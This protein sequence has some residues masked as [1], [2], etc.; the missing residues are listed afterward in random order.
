VVCDIPLESFSKNY[1]FGSDVTSIRDLHTKLWSSQVVKVSISRISGL[2]L[3]GPGTTCH[4]GVGPVV[5]HRVYYK[6][7]GGGFR[8]VRVVMSLVSPC[9]PMVRPGPK[10]FKLR[11]NQLVVWFVQVRVNN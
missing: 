6:G 1:N 7:E 4:L 9:L 3:G 11:I 5:R 8:Q 2:P 10:V